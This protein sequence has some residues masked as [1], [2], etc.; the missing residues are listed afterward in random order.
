MSN[1]QHIKGS[2]TRVL[3]TF[4]TKTL[5]NDGDIVIARINGKGVFLCSKAGGMWY[6]ANKMQELSKLEKT[7]IRELT[8]NKLTV[9]KMIN[10]ENSPDKFVVSDSGNIKYMTGNQ[11][12]GDL[13]LPFKNIAYKTAYCSLGQYSDKGSCEASGGTWY[14]SEN[15]SHDSISSTAENQLLTIGQSIGGVDAEPTL[16]YDGSTLEIKRNTDFDDN[17]QTSTQDALLKLSYDSSNT[18]GLAITIE[19]H[20]A[21]TI[22]TVDGAAEA[23]HLTLDVDGDITL[24]AAG[25]DIQIEK[26]GTNFGSINTTTGGKL[27]LKGNTNVH[28]VLESSGTGDILLSSLDDISIYATDTLTLNSDGTFIMK[29]DNVEYSVANSAYAGMILG[30]RMIGEDAGHS[31]YTLTTSYVVPNSDMTVRF[32]AP[33]SGSVEVM[34]QINLDSNSGRP[35]TFGLS[36]N[37]TY[38]SLGDSYQ[39]V[40]GMVD[41]TDNYVHQHY[42]TVTGLTAGSTYNYWLGASANGGY[43]GWGGTGSGRF[44]DFIMKVTALPTAVSDFAVYD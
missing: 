3:N 38:N 14:Y 13:P 8:T 22:S 37:A 23:A 7:S 17:W 40:T 15:D 41:E 31:T 43:L 6:A 33:P 44:C 18:D 12:V 27:K 9:S 19:E 4:P 21:T 10:T 36:D 5:G 2:R 16:T 35:V 1:L 25:A 32:I 11:V 39:Q 26:D 42:W 20:G 30:Y 34:V 24:D 29:K 28:V